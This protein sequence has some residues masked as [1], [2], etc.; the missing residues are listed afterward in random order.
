MIWTI[1]PNV[2][3]RSRRASN[4]SY[5]KRTRARRRVVRDSSAS[6]FVVDVR[7][8][9]HF[10][11]ELPQQRK[12]MIVE[13]AP[14]NA[15]LRYA[16][17]SAN[18]LYYLNRLFA[19]RCIDVSPSILIRSSQD[20]IPPGQFLFYAHYHFR[21]PFCSRDEVAPHDVIEG[22]GALTRGFEPHRGKHR[23]QSAL[24]ILPVSRLERGENAHRS[25][26]TEV[27]EQ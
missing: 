4:A 16:G 10:V 22:D 18:S 21:P 17:E 5:G 12:V 13:H 6:S 11:S 26:G 27:G 3:A 14:R 9:E 1:M 15:A 20:N 25:F 7:A 24:G 8:A 2:R 23:N 19:R